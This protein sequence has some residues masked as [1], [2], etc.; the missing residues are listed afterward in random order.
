V[1]CDRC[2]SVR[3]LD[4]SAKASDCWGWTFNGQESDGYAP[5]VNGFCGGDYLD[6]TLCLDCGKIQ[7]EFPVEFEE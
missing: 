7:G 2:A 1:K 4:I 6:T 3:L 5:H